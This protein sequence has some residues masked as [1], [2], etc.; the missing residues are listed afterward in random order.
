V[1]DKIEL[2]SGIR[3]RLYKGDIRDQ[4]LLDKL[5]RDQ[6][7]DAVIHFAGLK[8]ARESMDKPVDYYENNVGGSVNF[9]AAM[10]SAKINT[11]INSSSA[12]VYGEQDTVPI[13]EDAPCNAANP[14]GRSKLV[15]ENI[16]LDLFTAEPD[17]KIARLRYFNPV[18]AHQSG[19][20][21]DDTGGISDNLIP[22]IV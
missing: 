22:Y 16:L 7:F 3:P 11:I 4:S 15:V 2:I 19:L 18:G 20:I 21:G 13:R 5:F 9:L 1:L 14:Y 12:A 17:W 10:K 6:A 8:S